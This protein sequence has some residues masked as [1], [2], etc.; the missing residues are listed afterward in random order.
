MHQDW[1]LTLEDVCAP[2]AGLQ[3]RSLRPA[4]GIVVEE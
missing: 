2:E 1:G 4:R 3:W